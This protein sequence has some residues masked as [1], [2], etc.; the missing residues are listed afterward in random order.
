M[1]NTSNHTLQNQLKFLIDNLEQGADLYVT[2]EGR[3][4]CFKSLLVEIKQ[5]NLIMKHNIGLIQDNTVLFPT[6]SLFKTDF[7]PPKELLKTCQDLLR[8]NPLAPPQL[9]KAIDELR[10]LLQEADT[11][12][13]S[14][15]TQKMLE[16]YDV[17]WNRFY[18]KKWPIMQREVQASLIACLPLAPYSRQRALILH[19]EETVDA[20]NAHIIAFHVEGGGDLLDEISQDGQLIPD[21]IAPILYN[22]RAELKNNTCIYDFF[23]L[24]MT[25]NLLNDELDKIPAR[26]ANGEQHQLET[27]FLD[28]GHK[29]QYDVNTAYADRFDDLLINICR[30]PDLALAF[31]KST[32]S[33]PFN[34]KLAYNLFGV[35][36]TKNV[37]KL[38]SVAPLRKRLTT[39]RVD[40][41]FKEYLYKDYESYTSEL[42][43]DLLETA[44][45]TI[46]AWKQ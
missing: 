13:N 38:L 25:Y 35:M 7:K 44:Y 45:Q 27:W 24:F 1:K 40:E 11:N 26:Q 39:K 19:I 2:D 32:L 23:R 3:K 10:D 31:K 30:Q 41:Y 33:E 29:L 4:A 8:E 6:Q 17:L 36:I 43:P 21:I 14:P 46:D 5:I 28:L 20:L 18:S 9:I 16:Y 22:Y 37:F 15:T 42:S 34:L 12:L